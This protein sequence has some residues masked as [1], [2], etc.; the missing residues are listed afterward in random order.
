MNRLMDVKLGV[1]KY[2]NAMSVQVEVPIRF[3]MKDL[4][5]YEFKSAVSGKLQVASSRRQCL[6]DIKFKFKSNASNDWYSMVHQVKVFKLKTID[7]IKFVVSSL[8]VF[9]HHDGLLFELSMSISIL[10]S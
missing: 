9:K 6:V 5:K 2:I 8:Q 7:V 10:K 4:Q 3:K 1:P